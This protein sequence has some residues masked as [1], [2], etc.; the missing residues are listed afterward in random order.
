M[1]ENKENVD[2]KMSF[3]VRIDTGWWKVLQ[4]LRASS[5]KSLKSLVEEALNRTYGTEK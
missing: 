1:H 2:K 3:Q 5:K 4:L